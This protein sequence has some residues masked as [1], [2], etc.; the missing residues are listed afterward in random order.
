[1]YETHPLKEIIGRA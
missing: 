1:M